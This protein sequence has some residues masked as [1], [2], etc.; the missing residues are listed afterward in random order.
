MGVARARP[1]EAA[2]L[3]YT[4]PQGCPGKAEVL[5]EIDP[6]VG[7]SWKP[8]AARL[9]A[10]ATVVHAALGRFELR[11]VLVRARRALRRAAR[12]ISCS[13]SSSS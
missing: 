5:D 13:P 10:S 3:A 11:V 9:M 2:D 6:L 1:A 7:A 12:G 8:G 4:S